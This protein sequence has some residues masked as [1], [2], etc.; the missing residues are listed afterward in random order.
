MVD[1]LHL[2]ISEFT[3]T[4]GGHFSIV[5]YP[6]P[7]GQMGDESNQP[8]LFRCEDG[9][10]VTGRKAYHN[11]RLFQLTVSRTKAGKVRAI[12]HLSVPKVYCGGL[13]NLKAI[14]SRE[15]FIECVDKIRSALGGIGFRCD[16][17]SARLLEVHIFR[18][19]YL[20]QSYSD[21]QYVLNRV[22]V[23][24][25]TRRI[26][27]E[28]T[29]YWHN[30]QEEICVYWK[31]KEVTEKNYRK[32]V[33]L[34]ILRFEYRLQKLEKVVQVLGMETVKDLMV[35]WDKLPVTFDSVCQRVLSGYEPFEMAG[36]IGELAELEDQLS[37]CR[38]Q[39][40]RFWMREY[41]AEI[42]L[43]SLVEGYSAKTVEETVKRVAGPTQAYRVCKQIEKLRKT[44]ASTR[45]A[46]D[47]GT[48]GSD[49]CTELLNK[50]ILEGKDLEE[51][52]FWDLLE[53]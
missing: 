18:D 20:N 3:V 8:V 15:Q 46:S 38:K 42:G 24:G 27:H 50:L 7:G 30:T 16:L 43:R 4:R 49:L 34:D 29:Y 31:S 35:G 37:N 13:N 9:T 23:R 53:S 26:E 11:G 10:M 45:V 17:Y 2:L 25:L 28:T 5:K 19:A 47:V 1:T 52:Q 6:V 51:R 21:Y 14:A 48:K 33:L 40:G 36:S 39:G 22:E 41:L 12:I 32:V 44:P